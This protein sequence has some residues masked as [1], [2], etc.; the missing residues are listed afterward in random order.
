[1]EWK[2]TWPKTEGG[3][4]ICN[5][6]TPMPE[7][8]RQWGSWEHDNVK[9]TNYDSDYSIEYKCHSCGHIWRIE[10]PD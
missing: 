7:A 6:D 3:R 10:M 8:G 4:Y 1:M 5:E 9:E 2:E